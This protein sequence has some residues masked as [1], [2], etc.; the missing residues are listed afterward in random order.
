MTQLLKEVD[1]DLGE[2]FKQFCR[3]LYQDNCKEREL[4]NEA[5]YDYSTYVTKNI[6]FLKDE[7]KVRGVSQKTTSPR[8]LVIGGV[9]VRNRWRNEP[10]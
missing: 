7:Y 2:D 1:G 9:I 8:Y 4:H 10:I 5:L 3:S 6:E